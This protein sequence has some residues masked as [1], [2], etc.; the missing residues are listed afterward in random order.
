MDFDMY[1][2]QIT[3]PNE[4]LRISLDQGDDSFRNAKLFL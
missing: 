3:L 1:P 4:V 2:N